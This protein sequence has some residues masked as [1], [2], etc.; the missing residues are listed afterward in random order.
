MTLTPTVYAVIL[1]IIMV[2]GLFA[3][4]FYHDFFYISKSDNDYMKKKKEEFDA[5]LKKPACI[6]QFCTKGG[7]VESVPYSA[8]LHPWDS[9]D[10]YTAKEI[11][12]DELDKSYKRGYFIDNKEMTYPACNILWARIQEKSDV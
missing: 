8:R 6:I 10:F 11:A 1:G 4:A 7:A 12:L 3:G 9:A 5:E 2:A